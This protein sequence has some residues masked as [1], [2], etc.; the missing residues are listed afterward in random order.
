MYTG[1]ERRSGRGQ[2]V[3][4]DFENRL[5][6]NDKSHTSSTSSQVLVRCEKLYSEYPLSLGIG[7]IFGKLMFN[8]IIIIVF[9][10]RTL[11]YKAPE[12]VLL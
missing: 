7:S 11:F 1:G 8:P 3:N 4:A 6:G 2:S 9:K 12:I 10:R 5:S